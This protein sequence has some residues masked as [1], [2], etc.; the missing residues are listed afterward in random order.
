MRTARSSS[1][2]VGDGLDHPVGQVV[3]HRHLDLQFRQEVHRV[4][5]A[6]VDFRVPLLPSE[7]LHFRDGEALDPELGQR[8]AYLV[9]L[10]RLD[11]GHDQLHVPAPSFVRRNGVPTGPQLKNRAGSGVTDKCLEIATNP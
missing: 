11:H 10:E 7:A 5:G 3:R 1:G 2:G 6:A 8:L 4:L 9:E